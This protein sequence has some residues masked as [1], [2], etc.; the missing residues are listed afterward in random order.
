MTTRFPVDTELM[1]LRGLARAGSVRRGE[2]LLTLSGEGPPLK[3]LH[4]VRPCPAEDAPVLLR[5][6][7]LAEASL[8][9]DLWLAA[10]HAV[11]VGE[12]MAAL[13]RLANGATITRAGAAPMQWVEL[14]L[15]RADILL[16]EGCAVGV[17]MR[18]LNAPEAAAALRARALALGWRDTEDPD[19]RVF[20]DGAELAPLLRTPD[21]CV[22]LLPPGAGPVQLRSRS[23][24]PAEYDPATG[25]GRQLGVAI[26]AILLDGEP[27]DPR[28]PVCAS[29]FAAPEPDLRWTDGEATLALPPRDDTML[30]ELHLRPYWSHYWI[31]PQAGD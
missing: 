24:I 22:V 14:R 23:A 29:G 11:R 12:T 18:G 15:E 31:P 13:G 8:R 26:A 1:A 27:L 17:A 16:A 30:L 2:M 28:G 6:G 9:R 19:L 21:D 4:A 5:A 20:A 7:A 3:P 25:D 10:S